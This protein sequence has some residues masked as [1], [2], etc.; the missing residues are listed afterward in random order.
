MNF[1]IW[2]L[3]LI[4]IFF[5]FVAEF[6][7]RA[8]GLGLRERYLVI[9]FS[10]VVVC[11]IFFLIAKYQD[12]FVPFI[13]KQK[14]ILYIWPF[15]IGLFLWF[16]MVS[17]QLSLSVLLNIC[18]VGFCAEIA[19]YYKISYGP[20]G[21]DFMLSAVMF[22]LF[23]IVTPIREELLYRCLINNRYLKSF[24]VRKSIFFTAILFAL[25][26]YKYFAFFIVFS[27]CM[28]FLIHRFKCFFPAVISH[29]TYNF[30]IYFIRVY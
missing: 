1:K 8:I 12:G 13:I 21:I 25:I 7:A 24:S 17:S 16:L 15:S 3:I 20:S 19:N 6:F 10:G 27:L 18:T 5:L 14:K 23:C 29:A 28:S 9:I 26:H 22:I 2:H 30:L 4:N 11:F